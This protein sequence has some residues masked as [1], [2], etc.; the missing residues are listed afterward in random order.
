[1]PPVQ[2]TGVE[3]EF[4]L[5][6]DEPRHALV[7]GGQ[8]LHR[9]AKIRRKFLPLAAAAA[10]GGGFRRQVPFFQIPGRQAQIAP[11][12]K[13]KVGFFIRQTKDFRLKMVGVAVADENK[14]RLV[15]QRR[16]S[17]LPPVKQQAHAVQLYQKTVMG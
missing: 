7:R 11:Q 14:Q 17:A 6:C 9:H 16:Q 5:R 4:P 2:I 1:M 8:R 3:N 10:L 12:Q 13:L 15:R